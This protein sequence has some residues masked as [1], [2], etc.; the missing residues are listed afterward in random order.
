[1]FT[2]ISLTDELDLRLD[3]QIMTHLIGIYGQSA[4]NYD[5]KHYLYVYESTVRLL[6]IPL[7][8]I[9]KRG[10]HPKTIS[11]TGKRKSRLNIWA[12]ISYQEATDYSVV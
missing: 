1:M 5:F 10:S 2:Q 7:Y 3:S 6:E 9:K 12:G 11:K 4:K 8:P